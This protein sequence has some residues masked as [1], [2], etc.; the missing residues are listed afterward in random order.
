MPSAA[1]S[2]DTALIT[3]AASG[4]GAAFARNLAARRARL[5]LVDKDSERLAGAAASL[6]VEHGVKIETLDADLSQTAGQDAVVDLIARHRDLDLLINNAG[7]A[8]PGLIHELPEERHVEMMQVHAVAP[9]RFCRAALPAMMERGGGAII[10]VCAIAQYLDLAGQYGATK[11]F[12]DT[13][14]RN[15]RAEV[16]GHG[17]RIQSLTPGYT[18]SNIDTTFSEPRRNTVPGL[19]WSSAEMVADVSLRHLNSGK[20]RCTPGVLNQM[21][22][23]ALRHGLYSQW[24]VRRW[25]V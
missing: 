9:V 12:L 17:I 23:F 19:L 24:L 10:N 7:F 4:I 8:V 3:G 15:L 11:I 13:F 20:L 18:D 16:A 6:R 25:F 1:P 22:E 2:F 14:S 5:L 21:L